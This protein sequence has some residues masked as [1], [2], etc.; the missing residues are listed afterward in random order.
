MADSAR[1]CLVWLGRIVTSK[2]FSRCLIRKIGNVTGWG[3]K[4]TGRQILGGHSTVQCS[5]RSSSR[6]LA[7]TGAVTFPCGSAQVK[8]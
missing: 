8:Q 5:A 4:L 2:L 7:S 1:V 3:Y 6:R